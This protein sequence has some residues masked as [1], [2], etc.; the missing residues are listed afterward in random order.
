MYKTGIPACDALNELHIQG[1]IIPRIWFKT[2][3]KGDLKHPKPHLLAINILSDI[4]YWYRPK[5]I[6]DEISGEL[7]GYSK[8]FRSDLLQRS[9]DD[10]A[11]TY[12]CSND[13]VKEA[14]VFL[15]KKIGVISRVFRDV[16]VGGIR[17][18]NI[19]FLDLNV[20]RLRELTYPTGEIPTEG[21][22]KSS[23]RVEETSPETAGESPRT[24]TENI[25]TNIS[26]D[27]SQSIY[28]VAPGQKTYDNG[29]DRIDLHRHKTMV[30]GIIKDNIEYD[31]LCLDYDQERVDELSGLIVDTSV[32]CKRLS[33]LEG[34][35]CP[36]QML[37]DVF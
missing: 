34:R 8:K 3:V 15:E 27:I 17:C 26:S 18:N 23:R 10:L 35:I 36:S 32:L 28:P 2:I 4:V 29:I 16:T 12:S 20:D 19:M 5:E 24:N 25:V 37:K 6:R 21:A 14:V 33:V 22:G 7:K 11:E 13:T 31:I 9:Y 30:D 1:N